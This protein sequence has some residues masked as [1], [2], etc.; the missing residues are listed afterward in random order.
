MQVEDQI[1]DAKTL[2]DIIMMSPGTVRVYATHQP[3]KLPPSIKIGRFR[4]W[5]LSEV[6]KWIADLDSSQMGTSH[7]RGPGRPRKR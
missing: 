4:R 1:I 3:E 5:R 7:K 6:N 2:A